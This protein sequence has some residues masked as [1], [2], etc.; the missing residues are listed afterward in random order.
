M[1]QFW[2]K[3]LPAQVRQIVEAAEKVSLDRIR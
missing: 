3:W 2:K 1:A